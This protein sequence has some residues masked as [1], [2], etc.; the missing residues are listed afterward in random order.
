VS[1]AADADRSHSAEAP[2]TA[3]ARWLEL[4]DIR[5]EVEELREVF[6]ADDICAASALCDQHAP[7]DVAF[8]VVG[9]DAA[10]ERL[11]YGQLAEESRRLAT[12]LRARG[13]AAGDRV[14][15]L[16]SKRR[17]LPIVLLALWRLGAVHVPLFTAF[18]APAIE[19]RVRDAAASLIVTEAGQRAKIDD[20]GIPILQ[21]GTDLDI[22]ISSN[23]PLVDSILTGPNE[24]IVQLYTSGTTG[25]PKAVGVPARAIASFI[26]YMRYGLDVNENDV[27]WNAADPG[28]AYGLYYGIIGPLAIG[29]ANVLLTAGFSAEL[30]VRVLREIGVTNFAAAPTVYRA[31]RAAG[32]NLGEHRLRTASS[33]GEP[34]TADVV[35][36]A[37]DALGTTVRDHFGQTEQGMIIVDP[38]EP[39]LRRTLPDGSMGQALPG[40]VAGTVGNAIALSVTDSPL[41]WFN[42]YLGAPAETEKRFVVDQQ[43]YLTGDVGRQELGDFYFASRADDIILAAGYRISPGDIEQIVCSD[44]AVAEA[45]VVGRPDEIRGEVIEAFVVLRPGSTAGEGLSTRLQDLVRSR[46]GTHAYPRRVHVVETLPRTSSGKLQRFVLRELSDSQVAHLRGEQVQEGGA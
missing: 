28:W 24:L 29:R 42:G 15:V 27:F 13:I 45:A 12:G 4:P 46:Y 16:M 32:I 1:E 3:R 14:A 6:A 39:R 38:W 18:A 9:E 34:L 37:P 8:V 11:T 44:P 30:T 19:V 21:A 2:V 41:M 33:A 17:E 40:F 23:E 20:L 7:D 26:S 22:M 31:L 10:V 25:T 36:W 35:A 43:W 5:A